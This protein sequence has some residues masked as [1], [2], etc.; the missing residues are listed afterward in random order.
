MFRTASFDDRLM[1][2]PSEESYDFYHV[3]TGQGYYI[4]FTP[5]SDTKFCPRGNFPSRL[6]SRSVPRR[7][8]SLVNF[9]INRSLQ[10]DS[11]INPQEQRRR[12]DSFLSPKSVGH[13][14]INKNLSLSRSAKILKALNIEYSPVMN[15]DYK[16][17]NKTLTFDL[18]PN[19]SRFKSPTSTATNSQTRRCKLS[20]LSLQSNG[21]NKSLNFDSCDDSPVASAHDT[22]IESIDENQ[23]QTPSSQRSRKIKKTLSYLSLSSGGS[24]TSSSFEFNLLSS[25]GL[26]TELREKIDDIVVT[27]MVTTPQLKLMSS[28]HKQLVNDDEITVSTPRN[29]YKDFTDDDNDDE[30]PETPVNVI[31]LIPESMSAIKKSHRKERFTGRFMNRINQNSTEEPLETDIDSEERPTTPLTSDVQSP[32]F[33]IHS[34]K[35]SHK[36]DKSKK[37]LC[38]NHSEDELSDTGSLFEY[39]LIEEQKE[40]EE[41]EEE[42]LKLNSSKNLSPVQVNEEMEFQTPPKTGQCHE[43]K[44]PGPATP[45]ASTSGRITPEN[46]IDYLKRIMTDSIKKSH[47]KLKDSNKKK[48]FK[49]RLIERQQDNVS[50]LKN[51]LNLNE[52]T[53]QEIIPSKSSDTDTGDRAGTPE[54]MNSSRLLLSKFSS[55]KKSHRKDKHR[56]IGFAQRHIMMNESNESSSPEAECNKSPS[57]RLLNIPQITI[58]EAST[59]KSSNDLSTSLHHDNNRYQS[60]HQSVLDSE[61]GDFKLIS[62]PNKR[63]SPNVSSCSSTE[64]D[65][66]SSELKLMDCQSP[67]EEFK[68]FTPIKKRKSIGKLNKSDLNECVFSTPKKPVVEICSDRCETPRLGMSILIP[69][70]DNDVVKNKYSN[71]NNNNDDDNDNVKEGD[72]ANV[73][74]T[75]SDDDTNGRQTPD[76]LNHI[77]MISSLSSIKKSHRKDKWAKVRTR[78]SSRLL[79]KKNRNSN[80]KNDL[81]DLSTVNNT[82]WRHNN[83]TFDSSPDSMEKHESSEELTSPRPSTSSANNS[84]PDNNNC[85]SN[86]ETINTPPNSLKVKTY[87]RLIQNTSIKR[88]HKKMREKKKQDSIICADNDDNLSD[89]GS[90]FD[91]KDKIIDYEN[92]GSMEDDDIKPLDDDNDDHHDKVFS[93]RTYSKSFNSNRSNDGSIFGSDDEMNS[94]SK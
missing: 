32:N 85:D 41:E 15:N 80:G 58:T 44:T 49:S 7:N 23:N 10:F 79:L 69:A 53:D 19:S 92:S 5:P 68:I 48:L 88:S 50:M 71:N 60:L 59:S 30:R 77:K 83:L 2:P 70:D 90:I 56:K 62:S 82:N 29:L 34:I 81:K 16:K 54:N 26:R 61:D 46:R 42:K 93:K 6:L 25:P 28:G 13:S 1:N 76:N 4:K 65:T 64:A 39:S 47:K 9:K 67:E 57:K 86:T 84:S 87:L 3:E 38:V 72:D 33:S 51:E 20:D 73:E 74:R 55:V 52:S 36:K 11:N 66:S 75:Q 40:K 94:P 37:K 45:R 12:S 27:S 91:E 18:T 17:I 89:D 63:K 21:I 24:G 22:S 8:R 35:K 78:E 14:P 43:P 31:R